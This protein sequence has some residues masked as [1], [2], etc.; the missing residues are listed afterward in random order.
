MIQPLFIRSI[1]MLIH[2]V[3]GRYTILLHRDGGRADRPLARMKEKYF[4]SFASS[5]D[6]QNMKQT[7]YIILYADK[8]RSTLVQFLATKS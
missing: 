8:F 2:D 1:V 3:Y 6:L 5:A 7:V 4:N